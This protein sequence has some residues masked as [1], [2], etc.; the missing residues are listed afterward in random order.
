MDGVIADFDKK[1]RQI[2][3]TLSTRCDGDD[4][5]ARAR[6]VDGICE[7]NPRIFLHLDLIKGAREAIWNLERHYEI[8]FASTPMWNVPNSFTDKRLWLENMIGE[9]ATKRL[10]LTHRKD[11]LIGDYLVDD[12]LKH[13]VLD[14]R[15]KHIH[16]GQPDF[17]DWNAVETYLMKEIGL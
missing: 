10:I 6:R 9:S 11:L 14:F 3:P 15:G 7:V 12:R 2:D 4:Y 13:G 17:P 16:F 1:I 5:E 8:Y